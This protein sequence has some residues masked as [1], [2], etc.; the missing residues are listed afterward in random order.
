MSGRRD[1]PKCASHAKLKR[2]S[3][4]PV[5][6]PYKPMNPARGTREWFSYTIEHVFFIQSHSFPLRSHRCWYWALSSVLPLI[7]QSPT[8]LKGIFVPL[9]N[10]L[11]DE[12]ILSSVNSICSYLLG[13]NIAFL[14]SV[15]DDFP[16]C[17]MDFISLRMHVISAIP[18]QLNCLRSLRHTRNSSLLHIRILNTVTAYLVMEGWHRQFDK[19]YSIFTININYD[20]KIKRRR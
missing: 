6:Q 1:H 12:A 14:P 20:R 7:S 5:L 2:S 16:S 13:L 17:C 9:G 15:L 18:R 8:H 19:F 11:F 4:W 3:D 10:Q